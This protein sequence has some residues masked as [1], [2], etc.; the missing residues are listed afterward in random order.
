MKNSPYSAGP[1]DRQARPRETLDNPT[2]EQQA[3]GVLAA[4][5][6]FDAELRR[7]PNSTFGPIA[8]EDWKPCEAAS[9][10]LMAAARAYADSLKGGTK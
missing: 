3:Q 2:P 9:H 4:C 5:L 1:A 8:E 10:R 6:A 7:L